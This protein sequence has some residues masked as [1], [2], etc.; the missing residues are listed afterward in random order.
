[1]IRE[2]IKSEKIRWSLHF[3]HLAAKKSNWKPK[4][5]STCDHLMNCVK[6]KENT[7]GMLTCRRHEFSW[8]ALRWHNWASFRLSRLPQGPVQYIQLFSNNEWIIQ[9]WRMKISRRNLKHSSNVEV[10]IINSLVVFGQSRAEI[11]EH[12]FKKIFSNKSLK[13]W[14]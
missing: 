12:F 8:I 1:M 6:W 4:N 3:K 5:K 7:L 9:V 2:R 11:P 14:S 10:D 13:I